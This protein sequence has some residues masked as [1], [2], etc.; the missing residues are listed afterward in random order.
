MSGIKAIPFAAMLALAAAANPAGANAPSCSSS[1][2]Q[3]ITAVEPG[4]TQTSGTKSVTAGVGPLR[5]TPSRISVST[6]FYRINSGAFTSAPGT[7][8]NGDKV[9]LRQVASSS[10]STAATQ[11]VSI[12]GQPDRVFRVIT[13]EGDPAPEPPVPPP[14]VIT[15]EPARIDWSTYGKL[16]LPVD[17]DGK[18]GADEIGASDLGNYSS[19]YWYNPSQGQLTQSGHVA[20]AGETVFWTP[21]NGNATTTNSSYPRTEMREMA[22]LV[23]LRND[24][25]LMGTHIQRGTVAVTHIQDA[26]DGKSRV[27]LVFAQLHSPNNSPPV[28]LYFQRLANGNTEVLSNYNTTPEGGSSANSSVKVAVALGEKFDYEIRLVDGILTTLVNGKVLDV[29]DMTRAWRN[30]L[31]FFKAG[32]YLGSN[33]QTG[34]GYGE[35]VY[36][37]LEVIH[38]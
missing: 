26:L 14:P 33:I 34:T 21:V 2:V 7:V 15:P 12:E 17:E 22:S 6:G 19:V 37:K 10:Y 8:A 28:K 9:T 31:F 23:G 25:A 30:D 36:S 32:S 5:L 3:C 24:W 29:R 1:D 38:Q 27:F 4:S 18:A 13:R 20:T 11:T 35:V 16:T